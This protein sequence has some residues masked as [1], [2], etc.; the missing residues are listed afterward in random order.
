MI[1]HIV[2]GVVEDG[3]RSRSFLH[4]NPTVIPA[5]KLKASKTG[6]GK[7]QICRKTTVDKKA[8][9]FSPLPPGNDEPG[10]PMRLLAPYR[11]TAAP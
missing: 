9:V 11:R 5:R 4:P 1:A 10:V 2:V 6:R 7:S 8:V 3:E